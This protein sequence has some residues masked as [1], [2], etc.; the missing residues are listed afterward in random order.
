VADIVTG[1][2]LTWFPAGHNPDELLEAFPEDDPHYG[3]VA[4]TSKVE[5]L[6]EI[7]LTQFAPD[8][9]VREPTD[10]APA[11]AAEIVGALNVT[12]GVSW[13]IGPDAWVDLGAEETVARVRRQYGLAERGLTDVLFDGLYLSALPEAQWLKAA[14][15]EDSVQELRYVVWDGDTDPDETGGGDG[16]APDTSLA[17]DRPTVLVTLGTVYTWHTELLELFLRALA[18]EDVTVVCTMGDDGD[19]SELGSIPDNV[20]FAGYRPHSEILPGCA[21][22]VCHGGFNTVMGALLCGVPVLCVPLGSDHELNAQL[23]TDLG[24]GLTVAH[25][26]ATPELIRAAVRRL[27]DEPAFAEEV[28][29][30]V[31]QM[32][33]RPSLGA[34]VHR[35]A[36]LARSRQPASD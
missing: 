9:I 17:G 1:A 15:P 35:M 2:G 4:V 11:I 8:I 14:L 7:A 30:F 25:E 21:A 26:E 28:G 5:D 18:D 33:R 6:V 22:M 19:L 3:D 12:Y 16:D 31:Q 27:I 34:A 32:E 36:Q 20:V 29:A 13:F 23:C 10:L 24:Y